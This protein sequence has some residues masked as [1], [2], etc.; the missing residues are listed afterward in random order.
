MYIFLFLR[1]FLTVFFFNNLKDVQ[2]T[3]EQH[4]FELGG[5]TYKQIRRQYFLSVVGNP[6]LRRVDLKLYANLT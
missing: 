2:L 5:S 4:I 3:L 6:G 1:I